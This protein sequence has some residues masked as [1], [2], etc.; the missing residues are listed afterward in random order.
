MEVTVELTPDE[1]A[2]RLEEMA[3]AGAYHKLTPDARALLFVVAK[4]VRN[5]GGTY[6]KGA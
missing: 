3:R 1:V 4:M 5:V 2:N 6:V